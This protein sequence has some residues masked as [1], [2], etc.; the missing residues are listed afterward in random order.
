MLTDS[1]FEAF[2]RYERRHGLPEG[3]IRMLNATNPHDNA[4]A[5]LERNEITFEA[6]CDAFEAEAAAAGGR[7]DARELFG[8]LRGELRPAMVDVVRRC[9]ERWRTGLLTN[10]FAVDDVGPPRM[11]PAHAELR[12]LFDVVVESAVVG[13][14]KPDPRVYQLACDAL[15]V[16]PAS[17]VF[18]DDLGIN[19]KPARAMGMRTIK[20][21]DWR[22]AIAELEEVL[23]VALH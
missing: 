3:F 20:V 4:W 10:T 2:A 19:L 18:L 17:T 12:A 16:E 14:R 21:D 22:R 23:G 15:G 8:F 6:F 5:R 13:L 1:P 11:G 9:R 7:V